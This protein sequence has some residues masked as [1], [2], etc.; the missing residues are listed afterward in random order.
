MK[1]ARIIIGIL[2]IISIIAGCAYFYQTQEDIDT[3]SP[4]LQADTDDITVSINATGKELKTGVHA[5][6]NRDGDISQNILIEKI[7][8]KEDGAGNEFLI[9]YVAFDQ[10]NN[11]GRLTRTLFYEDYRQTHFNLSVPLRFPENQKV[12]LLEYFEADDCIDGEI[13]SFIMMEGAKEILEEPQKGIYDCILSITNSV[14]DTTELPIEVEIYEDGYD[15]RSLRPQIFLNQYIVYIKQGEDLNAISYL[16]HIQDGG[17]KLIDSNSVSSDQSVGDSTG[18]TSN[19]T[20]S[21]RVNVSQIKIDSTVEKNKPGVYSVVY[22]YTSPETE[23]SCNT[24]LIVV[25]E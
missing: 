9:T 14:G 23:Y 3:E 19:T 13:S 8:K 10:A 15:E 5:S 12:P 24:K 6:D 25:V 17:T 11:S 18:K 7:E 21:D 1:K 2:C 20:G 16:D 4:V 22:S